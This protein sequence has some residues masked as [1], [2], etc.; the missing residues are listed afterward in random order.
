MND[1][2]ENLVLEPSSA[3]SAHGSETAAPL[4]ELD[5]ASF[6]IDNRVLLEPLSLTLPAGSLA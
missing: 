2:S 3:L 6:T 1:I 4:F 5:G